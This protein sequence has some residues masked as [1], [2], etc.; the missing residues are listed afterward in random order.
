[1]IRKSI[2]GP[3]P[4]Q[5]R[6]MVRYGSNFGLESWCNDGSSGEPPNVSLRSCTRGQA[7]SPKF[8][9]PLL[10]LQSVAYGPGKGQYVDMDMRDARM[11]ADCLSAEHRDGHGKMIH[12]EDERVLVASCACPQHMARDNAT[13]KYSEHVLNGYDSIFAAGGSGIA[14]LLGIPLSLRLR[15]P[16]S[17]HAEGLRNREAMLLM[18]DITSPTVGSDPFFTRF[19]NR[20][21]IGENGFGSSPLLWSRDVVGSV[22]VGRAD[23]LPLLSQHLEA[24][25]KYIETRVEPRIAAAISNLSPL[26]IVSAREIILNSITRTDFLVFFRAMQVERAASNDDWQNLPSPYHVTR[27]GQAARINALWEAQTRAGFIQQSDAPRRIRVFGIE[28]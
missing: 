26:E 21:Y 22:F 7:C 16:M 8:K 4:I 9:G 25:C 27:A 15:E 19:P 28:A 1:M 2:V 23:G 13:S 12:L 6:D 3:N 18:R 17:I 5:A 24:L 10:V 14:N 20:D 11:T